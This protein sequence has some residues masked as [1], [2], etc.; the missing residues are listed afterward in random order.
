MIFSCSMIEPGPPVRDDERQR[1]RV[2]GADVDEVDVQPIDVG[3]ELRQGVQP[4]L[5]LAPV[6]V[7]RPIA[8]ELS[9]RREPH[10][11]RLIGDQFLFGPAGASRLGGGDRRA[12]LPASRRG[13]DGWT[14]RPPHRSEHRWTSGSRAGQG[15]SHQRLRALGSY[16]RRFSSGPVWWRVLRQTLF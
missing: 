4:R 14:Y 8:R 7:G 3:D 12:P 1:V 2:L 16:S 5:A 6:V 9:H 15:P 11:L 10:A 13:T